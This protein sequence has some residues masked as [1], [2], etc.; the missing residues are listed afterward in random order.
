[1]HL[2]F[3]IVRLPAAA[4][5]TYSANSFLQVSQLQRLFFKHWPQLYD[6]ALANCAAACAPDGLRRALRQLQGEELRQL[7]C[8]QLRLV[9]EDDPWAQVRFEGEC[10]LSKVFPLKYSYAHWC[11]AGCSQMQLVE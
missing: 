10:I 11:G 6:M 9:G 5:V 2:L 1:L 7:V 8:K 3:T 4:A